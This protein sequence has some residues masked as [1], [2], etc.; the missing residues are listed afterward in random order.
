MQD[1]DTPSR[2]GDQVGKLKQNLKE[3]DEDLK[4]N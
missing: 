3:K 4:C 2:E 1:D